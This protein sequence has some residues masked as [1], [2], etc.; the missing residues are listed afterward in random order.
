MF[1]QQDQA[2][3]YTSDGVPVGEPVLCLHDLVK[4]ATHLDDD[5]IFGHLRRHDFSQWLEKVFGDDELAELMYKLESNF[6][7]I[8]SASEFS[9]QLIE[10]IE[11]KYGSKAA[12]LEL[13]T[14]VNADIGGNTQVN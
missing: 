5:V 3:V 10:L 2:F 13:N 1:L 4:S 14:E 6:E 9:E 8:G 7:Q 11:Q 12:L